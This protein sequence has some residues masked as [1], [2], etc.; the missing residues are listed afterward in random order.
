MTVVGIDL[1][2]T[3]TVVAAA[4]QG[5]A[6]PL[7][8]DAGRSLLPSV[9][10]FHPNGDVLVGGPAKERRTVDAQNTIFSVKRLIGRSWDNEQVQRARTRL[11]FVMKEGPG[12][13]ILVEARGHTYTLAEISAF[14]L[15]RAK[16]IAEAR[17]GEHVEECVI[18]V[19]ANFN[20]LQRAATKVAGRVAGLEV[21]RILNEPT[22]A[23][24]AYGFGKGG[25]ERL[26]V[27]DF[28]GGTFDITLLDLSENVFEVLAT[29]GDTFLGGD[30][31]DR[32]V[33]ERMA[34][35]LLSKHRVDASADP[36]LFE[37]LRAAAETLKIELTTATRARTTLPEVAH[38]AFGKALDFE[39]TLTRTE[40]ETLAA[41]LIDR[42]LDVCREALGVAGL[43]P[44]DFDQLLLVG[45]STRLPIVQRI[46]AEFW[47]RQPHGRINPDEV[48]AV[49]AAI[50]AAALGSSKRRPTEIPS[51]PIPARSLRP[52]PRSEMPSWTGEGPRPLLASIPP[53]TNLPPL[54]GKL[55]SSPS[56]TPGA[57]TPGVAPPG[58]GRTE[59]S[60]LSRFEARVSIA[61]GGAPRDSGAP[62]PSGSAPTPRNAPLPRNPFASSPLPSGSSAANRPGTS[63]PGKTAPAASAGA[64][65]KKEGGPSAPSTL[66]GVG[67]GLNKTVQGVAPP[68]VTAKGPPGAPPAPSPGNAP[69]SPAERRS[70]P[71]LRPLPVVPVEAEELDVD[72]DAL[73]PETPEVLSDDDL[74]G[75]DPPS[76]SEAAAELE[77][78]DIE[79]LASV[80]PP[81]E[82]PA[83]TQH[84]P[85]QR[86]GPG[87][88]GPSPLAA[89]PTPRGASPIPPFAPPAAERSNA[90]RPQGLPA[91]LE[92]PAAATR[93]AEL[94]LAPQGAPLPSVLPPALDS[95]PPAGTASELPSS[96]VLWEPAA[97]PPLLIDVTPLSL[98]VEVVGGYCDTLIERNSPVPCER[99]RQ[100]VTARDMQTSV[101][102]RVCQ[103]QSERFADNTLLGDLVLTGFRSAPR[104]AV[105]I[106]VTFA[107]DESGMLN[108][109]ARDPETGASTHA[110]LRLLGLGE[111]GRAP[112]GR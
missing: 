96:E 95:A 26:A 86:P 41:P 31:I 50:Q 37:R 68:P 29:A 79:A 64:S 71:E 85:E 89:P 8:D 24:L 36:Q 42:T 73:D 45:G 35:T 38:R 110:E 62:A 112:H 30:D 56:V 67:K 69:P 63:F 87:N 72:A 32:L 108:V 70:A 54:R 11:P 55:P 39:Y 21:L 102:V 103:G 75:T 88:L 18:T 5:R 74:F 66:L 9:V 43:N 7:K 25:R 3:N 52:G 22:A 1:G 46:A 14:V 34:E 97:A 107:L 51:A 93:D 101:R 10:S 17:L 49:G 23:A 91:V 57:A 53:Q 15:G 78:L 77:E 6:A 100:F 83:G 105:T 90:P 109:S 58:A 48:V 59:H 47:G 81:P 33:A 99:T 84:V 19:P 60:L 104:G 4:R 111:S 98:G 27:Y 40:L 92:P 61:D 94:P 2:T 44:Q 65:P 28:G 80:P 106:E 82:P 76:A 12:K 13:S 16:E 20:D